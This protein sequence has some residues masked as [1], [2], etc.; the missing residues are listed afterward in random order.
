M[1]AQLLDL[2]LGALAFFI[3]GFDSRLVLQ[4]LQLCED[5]TSPLFDGLSRLAQDRVIARWHRRHLGFSRLDF[6]D[7]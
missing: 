6:C 1:Q 2:F 4:L 3:D 5:P 7:C